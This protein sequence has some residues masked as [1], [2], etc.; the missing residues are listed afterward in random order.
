HGVMQ[1]P[2]HPRLPPTKVERRLA[3][4]GAGGILLSRGDGVRVSDLEV[5]ER[6]LEIPPHPRLRLPLEQRHERADRVDRDLRLR[7]LPPLE[8]AE[9]EREERRRR[10]EQEGADLDLPDRLGDLLERRLRP[11]PLRLLSQ[12]APPPGPARRRRRGGSRPP[13]SGRAAA[14]SRSGSGRRG[15]PPPRPR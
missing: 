15:T 11:G 5:R 14:R 13:R 3:R 6:P 9:A 12:S 2:I 10:R 7:E 4:R 8:L 1:E